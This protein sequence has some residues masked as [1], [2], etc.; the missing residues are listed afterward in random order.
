[1]PAAYT[2]LMISEKALEQFKAGE[3]IDRRIRRH[4]LTHSHFV[5]LGSVSPDYANLDF[6]KNHQTK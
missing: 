6:L 5:S 2:H 4:A 1:M 3:A